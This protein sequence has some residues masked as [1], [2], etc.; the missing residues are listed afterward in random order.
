[1]VNW[2]G[3][4]M[5]RSGRQGNIDPPPLGYVA[6]VILVFLVLR[7][8]ST[9]ERLAHV[10]ALLT[11]RGVYLPAMPSLPCPDPVHRRTQRQAA[12]I[13]SYRHRAVM[14]RP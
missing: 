10:E 6:A 8:L 13:P 7:R 9:C 4:T 1:M 3:Y 2:W 14:V 11:L 5:G 12:I